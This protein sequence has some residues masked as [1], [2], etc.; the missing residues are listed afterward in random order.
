MKNRKL[1]LICYD[2]ADD[3][4][5]R[6]ALKIVRHYATGGQKSVHECWLSKRE[7]REVIER[8]SELLHPTDDGL[9][10]VRLDPRQKAQVLGR[11]VVAENMEWFYI[12]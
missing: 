4:R 12:G 10:M 1:Y 11:G 3:K 9:L 7:K 6:A 8:F 2:V 5:L